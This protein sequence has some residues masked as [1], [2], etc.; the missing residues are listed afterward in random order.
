MKILFIIIAAVAHSVALCV[1]LCACTVS[2]GGSAQPVKVYSFNLRRFDAA[3]AADQNVAAFIAG[4]IEDAGIAALQE[5][6]GLD[7]PTMTAFAARAGANRAVL[8]GPPEGRTSIYKEQFAFLYNLDKVRLIS[9]ARYPDT[10][11]RFERPPLAAYFSTDP[12]AKSSAPSSDFIVINCHIKPDESRARTTAEIAL[13]PEVAAYFRSLWQE[14]DVLIVGDFNAGGIYYD[15]A[16][17]A[18]VFLPSRWTE[19]SGNDWDTTVSANTTAAYD[20][21]F[22]SKSAVEDWTGNA[23]ITRFDEWES[24]WRITSNPAAAISDHYPVWA[25]FGTG[26]DSD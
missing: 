18:G 2:P 1:A 17:L 22:I 15:P 9:S 8:L 19:L 3:K 7:V 16:N 20:R 21:F 23:G 12:A 10:G 11:G 24:C 13:L 14:P 25:E 5:I 4:L 26:A 6:I